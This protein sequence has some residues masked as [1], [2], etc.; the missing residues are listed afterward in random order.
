VHSLADPASR[1]S[2]DRHATR[3][4]FTLLEVLLTIALIAMLGAV[5]MGGAA[6]LLTDQ[7]VTANEVFWK[8]VQEARK[9]ALKGEKEIRLR[10]D[11]QKKQFLVLDGVAAPVLAADGFT[12][13]EPPAIK[14]LPIPPP[15]STDLTIDFLPS[16]TKGGNM[17]L[18]GGVAVESN[19]IPFV[20]FYPDG[21]C[22]PFRA[23]FMR[24]GA[25]HLLSVDPWTCAPMLVTDPNAPRTP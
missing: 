20:T 19:P 14:T 3:G 13:S 7:P 8:A 15:G 25:T 21:T 16:G 5:L 18:I 12:K 2:S 1:F 6:H 17:I 22:T 4:G 24:N 11:A 9:A 10:F 23:Q